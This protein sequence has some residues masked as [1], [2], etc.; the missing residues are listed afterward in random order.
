MLQNHKTETSAI[1]WSIFFLF[2][3]LYRTS[4]SILGH[5]VIMRFTSIGDTESYQSAAISTHLLKFQT[6]GNLSDFTKLGEF[7]AST[8]ITDWLGAQ[9]HFFLGGNPILINIAFQSITFVGLV[10]LLLSVP[11]SARL[12]LAGLLM[13]PSFT[14]WTSIASKESIV[15]SCVAIVAGYLI[16][17]YTMGSRLNLIHAFA[18]LLLYIFKPHYLIPIAYAWSTQTIGKWVKQKALLAY[19]G[20]LASLSGLIVFSE[21]IMELAFEV[22]WSFEIVADVRS[23]RLEPFFVDKMDVFLK[24][25]E[26]FYLAFMGP[27]LEEVMTSPLHLITFIE[28]SILLFVLL[29]TL[30]S[31][32]RDIPLYNMIVGMG[33]SFWVL[34]PNYSFGVMNPGSA[35]RYRSGWI[36]L[37]FLAISILTSRTLYQA[38]QRQKPTIFLKR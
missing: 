12:G 36:I 20:L 6:S 35:I 4:F 37:I 7:Q 2:L 1:S 18:L 38:W 32:F 22:Q 16:R 5:L 33:I 17:Q 13:L 10:Y 11:T 26:G 8:F 28:S 19:L 21:K 24:A 9:F 27:T 14:L 25:P 34:F 15:V 29:L 30:M 3:Y 23:T 31:R